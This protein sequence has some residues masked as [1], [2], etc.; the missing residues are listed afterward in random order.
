MIKM[1]TH[2][3]QFDS[4][5]D[6]IKHYKNFP[7]M[8]PY[9]GIN[10]NN[11]KQLKILLI[12][13]SNYLPEYSTIHKD[14]D[15]WYNS[16]QSNL[17]SKEIDWIHCRQLLEC[18]WKADG[19]MIYRELDRN[20]SDFFNHSIHRAMTNVAFMN[21]FQRPSPKTGDSI[22]KY[23]TD[24]DVKISSNIIKQVISIINPDLVIFVSKFTWDK[25][26][27]RLK[28]IKDKIKIDFT[29]HPGTGGRYW[30]N[31]DYKHGKEKFRKIIS[32][33]INDKEG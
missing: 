28:N 21:G 10:Y 3:N 13:E 2:T 33:T 1:E 23:L 24:Y 4:K 17:D 19:H 7:A 31:K 29:C 6:Q 20:L 5:F 25:L 16:N 11:S 30:H 9:V 26:N 18:D 15:K 14:V 8:K 12:G 22:S 27:G 32:Q